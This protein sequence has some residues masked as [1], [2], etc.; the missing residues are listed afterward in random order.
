MK[1]KLLVC[2]CAMAFA[3]LFL[4]GC[5]EET[6]FDAIVDQLSAQTL[7]GFFSGTESDANDL[8]L[9]V[10]Q[11]QFLDNDSVIRTTLELGDG[12]NGEP[13]IRKFASWTLCEFTNGGKARV[14][15]LNPVEGEEPLV[16]SFVNGGILEE[17]MPAAVDNNDKVAA[18][19]PTQNAIAKKW[20]GNDTTWF[21]VDTIVEEMYKDTTWG[22]RRKKDENGQYIFYYDEEGQKHYEMEEY[23]K[24]VEDK[25]REV[26]KKKNVTP[27]AVNIRELDLYRSENF[28][29]TGSW[30]MIVKTFDVNP[31][32]RVSTPK[33]DTTS[34]Y[35]FHWSLASFSSASSFVI[36]ARQADGKEELFD[37]KFDNKVPA[38]TLQ[39]Q[40]LNVKE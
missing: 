9:R 1:N 34:V 8:V 40:V 32:T 6:N 14:L 25:V 31:V 17:N 13:V 21:R 5:K 2:A 16:V 3:G 18:I 20:Y 24:K 11:Y 38:V 28:E 15:T 23:V 36:R 35:D 10:A 26:K 12:V 22:S 27:T 19:A 4:T 7:K 39:K 37:L 29:N 30:N 33:L